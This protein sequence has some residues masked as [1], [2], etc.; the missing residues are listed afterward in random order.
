[1]SVLRGDDGWCEV[2]VVVIPVDDVMRWDDE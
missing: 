2:C 1:V